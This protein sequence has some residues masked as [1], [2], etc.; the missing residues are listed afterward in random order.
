M[1]QKLGR[2]L[3][4]LLGESGMDGNLQSINGKVEN[5]GK[6]DINLIFQNEDQPRKFFDDSKLKELAE[7]IKLHGV[8]QP[9]AVRKKGNQYEIVAGERRW[10]ASKMAGLKEVPVHIVDCDDSKIM[11]LALIE[12]IQRADLNPIEEAE[13]MKTVISSCECTQ[14]DLSVMICKSRSYIANA[15]RLLT[16]PERVKDLIISGKLTAGHGKCLAGTQNAEEI[17]LLVANEGWTVRQLEAAMQDLKS[18]DPIKAQEIERGGV[19][20]YGTPIESYENPDAKEISD[21]ISEVLNIKAKLK[22]TRNGGVLTLTCTSCEDLENLTNT[23][24]AIGS[25]K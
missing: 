5:I 23:L 10:R 2:G 24:I 14:E 20:G 21:R 4:A 17:S 15:L 16:L 6:V 19:A 8:L 13:A 9:L 3:S 1:E 11:A 25:E 22:I 7:S 12:N 18:G